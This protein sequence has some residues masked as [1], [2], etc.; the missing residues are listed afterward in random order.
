MGL[1]GLRLPYALSNYFY[2]WKHLPNVRYTELVECIIPIAGEQCFKAAAF[3][4]A[5]VMAV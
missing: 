3:S 5:R 4:G 1:K 2:E